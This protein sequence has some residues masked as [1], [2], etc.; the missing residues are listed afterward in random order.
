MLTG[1][2]VGAHEGAASPFGPGDAWRHG[3]HWP[4]ERRR[5]RRRRRSD[6]GARQL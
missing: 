5:P 2:A 4:R 6:Q 3:P 1:R